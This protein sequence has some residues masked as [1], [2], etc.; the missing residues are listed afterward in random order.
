MPEVAQ[1]LQLL[2]RLCAVLPASQVH[3]TDC[4]GFDG[5]FESFCTI[6]QAYWQ[7]VPTDGEAWCILPSTSCFTVLC[8]LDAR[9][10]RQTANLMCSALAISCHELVPDTQS[11]G[12]SPAMDGYSTKKRSEVCVIMYNFTIHNS[13]LRRTCLIL[14]HLILETLSVPGWYLPSFSGRAQQAWLQREGK[15]TELIESSSMEYYGTGHWDYSV[16]RVQQRSI[17]ASRLDCMKQV[18]HLVLVWWV[19]WLW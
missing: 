17:S 16:P 2:L 7:E 15:R 1:K 11:F 4:H 3:P 6:W 18:D 14:L 9:E 13:C 19:L 12:S 5:S 10:H 8:T